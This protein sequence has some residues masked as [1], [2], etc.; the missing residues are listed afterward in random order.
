MSFQSDAEVAANVQVAGT[1]RSALFYDSVSHVWRT[2]DQAGTIDNLVNGVTSV[3]GQTGVVSLSSV[4][5]PLDADLTAI[6]AL[7]TTSYG[8]ALLTLANSAAL[9]AGVDLV[10]TS[11]RG[12]MAASDKSRMDN[13][14]NNAIYNVLDNGISTAN[15]GAQNVTAWNALMTA[16]PDN[17]TVFFPPSPSPY[18]FASVCAIPSGKHLRI[19]GSG[20]QKTIIR[21]TSGTANIFTVGDWY[22][23]FRDLKFTTSVTRTAGAAILSGDNVAVNVI[24]CDF[25]SMF[26]GIV[27]SGGVNAGNLALVDNCRFTNTVNFSIQ[28]DGTN[29]NAIIRSCVADCSPASVVHLEINACGSL[30]VSNCDFIRAVN[31]MRLNPDSGIKGVFSVYCINTFF[32]TS[33]G[34]SVKFQGGATGTNIQR[35]KFTNCWFSGGATGCEFAASTSTNKPTAIDFVSCDIFSNSANG[36]LATEVQDFSLSNCRIA[37]NTTAGVNV[38]AAASSATKVNIQNCTVGPTAGI[39][40][41]GIGIN[42]QSGTYGSINITGNTVSGNTSNNNIL[43]LSTVAT[44]DMKKIAD[45]LGHLIKGAIASQGGTPLSVPVTTETVVLAA[46]IPANSVTAGQVFR[47]RAIGVMSAANVPTWRVKVGANGTTADTACWTV[48]TAAGAANGR[49]GCDVL[50]TVRSATTV[51]A[52]GLGQ[53]GTTTTAITFAQP[54]LAAATT[55]AIVSSSVW[56]ITLTLSQ[57]IGSSLIQQAVIEA[58]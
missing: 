29:C 22:N 54:T 36:I 49:H 6:S 48:T 7:S 55:T 42:I 53:S 38:L 28:V 17:A 16:I 41:N 44:T 57:T 46:R 34:S 19:M 11:L 20:S 9:T 58:L 45:N 47:I 39:G 35:V 18:D 24:N 14:F 2:K 32:D 12:A 3:D 8:R 15:T 52:E 30:L 4:Y 21:T 23:E 25:A 40:A 56:F 5:Q 50:L 13:F 33:S 51:N 1:D 26:N 43:D 31:N 37:G 27:F 10:T